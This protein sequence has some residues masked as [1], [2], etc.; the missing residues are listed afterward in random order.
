MD[1]PQLT[2][3]SKLPKCHKVKTPHTFLAPLYFP[4]KKKKKKK[5]FI[6]STLLSPKKKNKNKEKTFLDLKFLFLSPPL[7]PDFHSDKKTLT[8]ALSV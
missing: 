7:P 4:R 6:G 8:S 1:K 2:Q 5:N 3:L